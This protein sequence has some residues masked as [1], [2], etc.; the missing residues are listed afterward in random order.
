MTI[1]SGRG[2]VGGKYREIIIVYRY[3]NGDRL[4]GGLWVSVLVFRWGLGDASVVGLLRYF[5]GLVRWSN[6]VAS[7]ECAQVLY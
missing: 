2:E 6:Y 7:D 1:I 5:Y 3:G 4:W